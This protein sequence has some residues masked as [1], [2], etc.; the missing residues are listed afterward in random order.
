MAGIYGNGIGLTEKMLDYLWARQSITL[1]NIAN[2]DTP[3]FKAQ[4]ITFEEELAKRL[5]NASAYRKAP[6]HAVAQAIED[7]RAQMHITWDESSR[8]DGNNVVMD[9]E[10]IEVVRTAYEYQY[11]LSSLNNDFTRLKSAAKTF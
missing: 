9:Q 11:M 2:V 1:N 7:S 4:Y 3:G 10:Q 8:L 5:K 6:K